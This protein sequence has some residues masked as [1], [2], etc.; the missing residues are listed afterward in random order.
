MLASFRCFALAFD[1]V[2]VEA[3]RLEVV[4][5]V[6]STFGEGNDMVSDEVFGKPDLLADVAGVL[7]TVEDV[8]ASGYCFWSSEPV[9]LFTGL[10]PC[11]AGVVLAGGKLKALRVTADFSCSHA[12]SCRRW[13]PL[14]V[15]VASGLS[16]HPLRLFR[17]QWQ[18]LP[19]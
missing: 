3:A 13:R 12:A 6:R 9:G 14:S 17:H 1:L 7:V 11:L 10:D 19:G 5:G 2:A 18:V 4:G 15:L 16:R 8:A